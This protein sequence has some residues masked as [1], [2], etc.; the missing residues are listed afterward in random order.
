MTSRG[1]GAF[2]QEFNLLGS[3]RRAACKIVFLGAAETQRQEFEFLIARFGRG[4]LGFSALARLWVG[5]R[6]ARKKRASTQPT[7]GPF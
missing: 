3:G 7:S 1:C 4:M 6:S 2:G 5:N